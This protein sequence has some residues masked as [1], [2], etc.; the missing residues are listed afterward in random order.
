MPHDTQNTNTAATS[1]WLRANSPST[2]D[3]P[4]PRPEDGTAA[5][6]KW[7]TP[8]VPYE[9]PGNDAKPT[10]AWECPMAMQ[11]RNWRDARDEALAEYTELSEQEN[12]WFTMAMKQYQDC[13]LLDE[14]LATCT[15]LCEADKARR[16][17]IG[18]WERCTQ[19][20]RR[21]EHERDKAQ[22]LVGKLS[23]K[24]FARLLDQF[25]A[26]GDRA[27]AIAERDE[28]LATCTG[29]SDERDEWQ[30]GC[31]NLA[32]KNVELEALILKD[33]IL[34]NE[35][36]EARAVARWLLAERDEARCEL[37]DSN[38]RRRDLRRA[39]EWSNRDRDEA[40]A[41]R[42]VARKELGAILDIKGL[43]WEYLARNYHQAIAERDDGHNW[44]GRMMNERDEAR[45]SLRSLACGGS[46]QGWRAL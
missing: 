16:N 7:R 9:G 40:R 35:R 11:C 1:D 30:A 28:V 41:E 42:D 14:A 45:A 19:T 13:Q 8:V 10:S 31:M 29:L 37:A 20:L 23:G 39:L 18:Q 26:E 5:P 43:D 22:T 46:G 38:E 15:E 33:C 6:G 25:T 27:V 44:A 4:A 32:R 12:R 3:A 34:L 17:V 21:C 36:D 2:G 24:A